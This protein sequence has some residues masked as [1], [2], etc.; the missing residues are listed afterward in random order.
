MNESFIYAREK[1][2][3]HIYKNKNSASIK[4]E[5]KY[6]KSTSNYKYT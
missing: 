1:V 5:L 3:L 2:N 6:L 4:S